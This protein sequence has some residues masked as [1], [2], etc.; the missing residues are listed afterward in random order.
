VKKLFDYQVI[1][2]KHC[3]PRF[4]TLVGHEQRV[5]KTA[6]AIETANLMKAKLVLCVVP[7]NTV[8]N[9]LVAMD[10]F[11]NGAWVGVVVSWAMAGKLLPRWHKLGLA[12]DLVVIDES[13]FAANREA[14]RTK[15]V[16][17]ATFEGSYALV[18]S[19]KKVICL[20]ATPMPN[21]PT[22]L[23]PMLRAIAP[24]L[25][26]RGN[27]KPMSYSMFCDTY[28]KRIRTPF[29]LKI[30]GGKN[31][32]QLRAKLKDSGFLI[33][34]TRQEVFGRDIRPPVKV[35]IS[36]PSEYRSQLK[37]LEKSPAGEAM[38]RALES[39]GLKALAKVNSPES[40]A[41]RQMFGMA[42]VPGVIS[43]AQEELD[44][45]PG[46]KL[47]IFA[48]HKEVVR[49]LTR[50]LHKYG[51]MSYYGGSGTRDEK[52]RINQKFLK[53]PKHRVIVCQIVAAAVGLDFSIA[54]HA[55]FAEESYVGTD[56][57]Q[58]CAR[59]FNVASTNPKF[60]SR[61]VLKGTMDEVI[62]NRADGKLKD[63][64]KILE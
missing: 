55:M 9:W 52:H 29:G 4:S 64:A 26:D 24:D 2:S 5:G 30:V 13:Q 7:A 62:A 14:A 49:A 33:R 60:I 32:A 16:Y 51:A 57:E 43:L 19:A 8:Q 22:G 27:G 31:H 42:K 61:I 38:I 45:E 12:P 50:G 47:V 54:D 21:S 1:D 44:A 40:G 58:A 20:T 18:E 17:G 28:C 15:A 6:V 56:N 25:I 10:E 3:L 39:G 11:R 36:P 41:L 37:V 59:I 63:A 35:Y 53:E 23:W 34:R 48:W 46:S